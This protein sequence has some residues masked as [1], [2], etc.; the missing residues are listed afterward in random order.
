MGAIIIV[1]GLPGTG[2][3]FFAQKLAESIKA[4][5]INSDSVRKSLALSGRYAMQDR[6]AVYHQMA[7]LS[8]PFLADGKSVIV[9]ATFHHHAMREIFVR[10]AQEQSTTTIRFIKVEADESV[11]KQR[12]LTPRPDSEADFTVYQKLKL[13]DEPLLIPHLTLRSEGS[14]EEMVNTA[15]QYLEQP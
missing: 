15:V 10:L 5:H 14:V 3:T 12:I 8:K 7:S 6:L 13:Q 1:C 4:V 11:I 9:D 2:K